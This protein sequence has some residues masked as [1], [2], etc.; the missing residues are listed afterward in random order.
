MR[1]SC[2]TAGNV[3]CSKVCHHGRME[4]WD[5]GLYWEHAALTKRRVWRARGYEP[6]VMIG[7]DEYW[8]YTLVLGPVVV[9]LWRMPEGRERIRSL[10]ASLD[11]MVE[12][13]IG[14]G[15]TSR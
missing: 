11:A 1:H 14:G 4:D 2:V 15:V 7:S 6:L 8:R 5:E 12:D 13:V 10:Q 3:S 9:A